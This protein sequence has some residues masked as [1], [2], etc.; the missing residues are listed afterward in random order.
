MSV[1][2]DE[3]GFSCPH[4]SGPMHREG[5]GAAC[6]AGHGFSAY[7]VL[8]ASSRESAAQAWRAVRSLENRQRSARWALSDP[9]LRVR[10]WVAGSALVD[11]QTAELLRAYARSLDKTLERLEAAPV[12]QPRPVAQVVELP[13]Q[14]GGPGTSPGPFAS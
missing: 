8:L 11:G 10:H 5:D 9:S 13:R 7:E 4:C 3:L 2:A 6:A 1:P 14:H 12:E